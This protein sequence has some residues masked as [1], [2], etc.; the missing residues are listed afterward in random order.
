MFTAKTFNNDWEMLDIDPSNKTFNDSRIS[1]FDIV[2]SSIMLWTSGVNEANAII[3]SS[4]FVSS[5]MAAS[6]ADAKTALAYG[7]ANGVSSIIKVPSQPF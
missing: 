2:G 3:F 5:I 7:L 4:S 1:S 6:K